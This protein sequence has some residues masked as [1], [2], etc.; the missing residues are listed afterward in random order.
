MDIF[1]WLE[2][3]GIR[4]N[5]KELI[6]EALTHSSYIN[7]NR[8]YKHHNERLEFMGDAVLQLWVSERLFSLSPALPEGKMSSMRQKLVCEQTLASFMRE[9]GIAKFMLLGV[10]EEKSGGR[11]RDSL[12]ADGF[13][14]FLGALYL[15]GSM[16]YVDIILNEVLLPMITHPDKNRIVDYKTTLQEYVQSDIRKSLK[17]IL[18]N[19][20]GPANEPTFEMGVY[21]DDV[22]LGK[23]EGP[24]KKKAEQLAAKE[25][26]DKLVK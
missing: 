22:L 23:G 13:E 17:Y 11:D 10:G 2:N 14:A 4:I 19:E 15:Q 9:L 12:L 7:E 5:N 21:L 20:T 18:L 1:E 24:T 8:D 6:I 25:A 26:L 16:K 3:R